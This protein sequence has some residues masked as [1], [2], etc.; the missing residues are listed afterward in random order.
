MEVG[1]PGLQLQ[2]PASDG[3]KL[4]GS[5]IKVEGRP[6][7]ARP[8]ASPN[9]SPGILIAKKPLKLSQNKFRHFLNT[10][11]LP[12]VSFGFPTGKVK[13]HSDRLLEHL[14]RLVKA[15]ARQRLANE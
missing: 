15:Q 12:P 13:F 4:P 7:L 8:G 6:R 1:L 2:T 3:A 5:G 11:P 10:N 9:G 14:M